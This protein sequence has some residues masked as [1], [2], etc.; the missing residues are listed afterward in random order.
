MK[1]RLLKILKNILAAKRDGISI[2]G[3]KRKRMRDVYAHK[4]GRLPRKYGW[5]PFF[6]IREKPFGNFPLEVSFWMHGGAR[7][8][9]SYKETCREEAQNEFYTFA[10]AYGV[11]LV[12]WVL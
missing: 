3:D 7:K 10:R 12:G 6:S 2:R 1:R 5:F 11:Q 8:K 9:R 4:K